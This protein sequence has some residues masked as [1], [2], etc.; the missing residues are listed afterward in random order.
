MANQLEPFL[1]VAPVLFIAMPTTVGWVLASGW[2]SCRD[3][4]VP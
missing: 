4:S 3:R 2:L 1:R